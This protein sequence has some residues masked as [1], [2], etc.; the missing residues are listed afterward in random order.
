M[1]QLN[2]LEKTGAFVIGAPFAALGIIVASAATGIPRA[3][4]GKVLW[5]WFITGVP[6]PSML[7]IYGGILLLSILMPV[8]FNR[9][10]EQALTTG[11]AFMFSM[12]Y[13]FIVV[14]LGWLARWVFA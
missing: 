8:S 5:G 12:M 11:E 4:A 1:S 14:G 3:W 6:V 7:A 13:P 2:F 9:P 10:K